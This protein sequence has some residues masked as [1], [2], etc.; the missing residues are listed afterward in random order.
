MTKY[1]IPLFLSLVCCRAEIVDRVSIVVDD[2]IIKHSDIIQ[3]IRLTD[4]LNHETPSFTL[5]E[6]KKAAARLID[7]TL[8]RK[9]LESG[10]Y[11]SPDPAEVDSLLQQIKRGFASDAAYQRALATYN[12][13]EAELRRRLDWQLTVLRFINLRF[14]A[15]APVTE[16]EAR[17][18][19]EK[20]LPE[21]KK[22]A[23]TAGDFEAARPE[24]EKAINGERVNQQFF[25]WL[26]D[27]EKNTPV[28]YNEV[29]L[30]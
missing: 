13:S 21:F 2:S 26:E 11:S 12:L 4:F 17:A 23:R 9:E 18:Y 8:I 29:D 30:K 7:Q 15:D 3:D 22:T 10:L 6:Q 25:A 28:T 24:I 14:G 16:A 19:Y 1:W 20:H 5:S 27:T